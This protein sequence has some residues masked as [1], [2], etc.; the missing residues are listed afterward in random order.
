VVAALALVGWRFDIGA[1]K[2]F[3]ADTAVM[4][5]NTEICIASLG[6]ALIASTH[7]FWGRVSR[8]FRVAFARLCTAAA[9]VIC[10][11]TLGRMSAA[12]AVTIAMLSGAL[13]SLDARTLAGKRVGQALALGALL[14]PAVALLGYLYGARALYEFKPFATMALHTT[15]VLTLLAVGVLFARPERAIVSELLKGNHGGFMARR[16]LPVAIVTPVIVG[17]LRIIGQRQ[18]LFG[19]EVGVAVLVAVTAFILGTLV[20]LIARLM[21]R[22]D[23]ER[24]AA[25]LQSLQAVRSAESRWRAL[26]EASAQIVWTADS[27]G[28]V[29]E[30]SPSWRAFTGQ[31]IQQAR[32]GHFGAIHPDDQARVSTEWRQAVTA[33]TA[34]ELEFRLR[35]VS[36]EW[37]WTLARAVPLR[38]TDGSVTSWVGMNIDITERKRAQQLAEGQKR[39]LEMIAR[40]APLAETLD[41]LTRLIDGQSEDMLSSILLLDADGQH[42]RH[43]AAPHLPEEYTKAIDGAA[44]GPN[45]GSCGTAAFNRRAVYVED[46]AVDPLWKDYK[47]LALAHGLRACWSTPILDA[48]GNVLGT[49]ALYYPRPALPSEANRRL[50]DLATQTAAICLTRHRAVQDRKRMQESQLRSQKLE[51]LGTLSGG[52]AHDFNNMLLVI[53]GNARLAAID[54]DAS[55]PAQVALTEITQASARASDLVR[56]ILAFSRPNSTK[57]KELQLQPVIAEALQLVRSTLPAMIEIRSSLPADLPVVAADTTQIHQILVNLATNAAHAMEVHGGVIDVRLACIDLTSQMAAC[58]PDLRPGRYVRLAVDDT[59][60]GMSPETMARIFDPFFT[61]KPLGQGTGLGL[62][63]V[64][65]IMQSCGGAVRVQSELGKGTTF[66]LYFPALQSESASGETTRLQAL[67]GGGQHILLI[68][69]EDSL[70][71]LGTIMLTRRGYRVTGCTDPAVA[72]KE[73]QRE[74]QSFDAVVTDLSMPGMSGFDCARELLGVRKDIPI[75][76][77]SGYVRP[78]DEA[79]ALKSGICAVVPKPGALDQLPEIL[80]R[81]FAVAG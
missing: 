18:G 16:L 57:H 3:M 70:V 54:L 63:I 42:L 22:L 72:V 51:A 39:V 26:V 77:T 31:S 27:A 30:S 67:P 41:A 8:R 7:G 60:T 78:E 66:H 48:E 23:A 74:P 44:I 29:I 21:N 64:H 46:I 17:G 79:H 32:D 13:L 1:L 20:W 11:V 14:V 24:R 53:A 76:L 2:S 61:T 28:N 55:H 68:D 50:I 33:R 35:H 47:H 38:G 12:A 45:V 25:D 73:F 81:V 49:F 4:R 36:G 71:R 40:D 6:T 19:N 52:I 56:R 34:F 5:P 37:R 80:A 59:G 15:A 69:D 75:V 9:L 43:G 10:A 65:G 58:G 62:S